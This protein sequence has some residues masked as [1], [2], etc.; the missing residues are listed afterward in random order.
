MKLKNILVIYMLLTVFLMGCGKTTAADNSQERPV[1]RKQVTIVANTS[2]SKED[3][4]KESTENSEE[5]SATE[6][7]KEVTPEGNIR[8]F[9]VNFQTGSEYPEGTE[10]NVDSAGTEDT[11][12]VAGDTDLVINFIFPV[13]IVD[14]V[15]VSPSGERFSKTTSELV[16]HDG[17]FGWAQGDNTTGHAWSTYRIN[18]AEVGKW[19]IEYNLGLNNSFENISIWSD[20]HTESLNNLN[21]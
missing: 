15:F 11:I 8:E 19:Y 5:S 1:I 4:V 17:N 7:L 20:F 12:L 10:F 13:E 3:P 14:I 6:N 18:D 2:A 21:N 9:L 16:G